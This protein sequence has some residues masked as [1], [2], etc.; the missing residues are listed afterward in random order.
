MLYFTV[1]K[2]KKYVYNE[3][4]QPREILQGRVFSSL[5]KIEKLILQNMRQ[6]TQPRKILC[7]DIS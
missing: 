4:T 5:C 1:Q 7:S 2:M 3:K 6:N